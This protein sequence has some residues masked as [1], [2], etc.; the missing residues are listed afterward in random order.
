MLY[1][2]NHIVLQLVINTNFS[3]S[4]PIIAPF[5]TQRAVM[6]RERSAGT[7]RTSSFFISKILVEVPTNVVRQVP[8]FCIFYWM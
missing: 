5:P 6:I 8:F 1:E 4:F 2:L 3:V 7:Y